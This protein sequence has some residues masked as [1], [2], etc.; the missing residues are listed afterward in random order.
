MI[1]QVAL[2]TLLLLTPATA[3]KADHQPECRN[4][5][6]QDLVAAGFTGESIRI[7][8]AIVMRESRGASL[9]EGSPWYTGALGAWQIQTSAHSSKPWWSRSGMLDRRT[10]SR[11]VFKYLSNRG[12]DW[13]P[14]GIS[15]DGKSVDATWYGG[16]SQYQISQW[17]WQPYAQFKSQFP[18]KCEGVLHASPRK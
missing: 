1:P 9:D 17:V 7:G 11:L 6:V 13:S 2:A 4:E 14:W 15:R 8:Y 5:I 16:W 18:R 3:A 10:Q 12:R